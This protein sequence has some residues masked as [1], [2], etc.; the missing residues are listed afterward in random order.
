M[1]SPGVVL[2]HPLQPD[3]GSTKT[4]YVIYAASHYNPT[5]NTGHI[6]TMGDFNADFTK[7]QTLPFT[8]PFPLILLW[9][10]YP[11]WWLTLRNRLPLS[12]T[13]HLKQLVHRNQTL[14]VSKLMSSF[15]SREKFKFLPTNLVAAR[16][17][18]LFLPWYLHWVPSSHE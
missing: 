17:Q 6:L 8:C 12:H 13:A 11:S 18:I 3:G 14:L 16:E 1:E 7:G 4:K 10:W 5:S 2:K 15:S 9:H